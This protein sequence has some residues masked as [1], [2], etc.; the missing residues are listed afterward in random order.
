MCECTKPPHLHNSF[1][2]SGTGSAKLPRA[3]FG[4]AV[5]QSVFLILGDFSVHTETAQIPC[6]P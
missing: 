3:V 6:Q 5:E 4:V 1:L 2:L